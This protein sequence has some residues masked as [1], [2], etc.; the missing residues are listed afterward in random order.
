MARRLVTRNSSARNIKRRIDSIKISLCNIANPGSH[1]LR[2]HGQSG[3]PYT[4]SK[5]ILHILDSVHG[6]LDDGH[7]REHVIQDLE[8]T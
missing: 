7:V 5:K 2:E 3:I 1:V 4:L 8:V 6:I